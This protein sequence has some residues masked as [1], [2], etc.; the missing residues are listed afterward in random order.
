MIVQEIGQAHDTPDDIIFDDLQETAF[1]GHSLGRSILGTPVSVRGL[2]SEALKCFLKERY[3]AG[4]LVI[5]VVGNVAHETIV[6]AAEE[7][8]GDLA[9][10]EAPALTQARFTAGRKDDHRPLEQVH[11][12]LAWPGAAFKGKDY[13][14][15]QVASTLLGGGMSSRLFQEVREARGLAYSVYSFA[16][17][18]LDCGLFSIYAGT[19]LK[20]AQE[21]LTVTKGEMSDMAEGIDEDELA[22]GKAQLKAGLLMGL[23]ATSARMEQLGRH[24]LIHGH[25]LTTEELI[26]AIDRVST[27]DVSRLIGDMMVQPPAFVALGGGDVEALTWD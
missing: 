12:A 2:T 25:P 14:G 15:L 18:H 24:M 23:E 11:L 13:Y 17:S 21:M 26:D 5:S 10:G 16:S 3:H 27:A 9:P 7:L 6:L 19:G 22:V 1:E 4:A 20:E 8:F